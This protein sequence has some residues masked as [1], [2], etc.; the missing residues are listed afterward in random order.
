MNRG[1]SPAFVIETALRL[2]EFEKLGIGLASP[3]VHVGYLKIGPVFGEVRGE[4]QTQIIQR[5]VAH[6]ISVAS[7]IREKLHRVLGLNVVGIF[8][9]ELCD[10]Q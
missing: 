8:S 9:H 4:N 6:V 3:K 1:V 2:E 10:K 5:T 7:V